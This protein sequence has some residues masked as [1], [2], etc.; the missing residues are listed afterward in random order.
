MFL[1]IILRHQRSQ[2]SM[3]LVHL[4]RI[5]KYNTFRAKPYVNFLKIH[6]NQQVSLYF[7]TLMKISR[8]LIKKRNFLETWFWRQVLQ[9]LAVIIKV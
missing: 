4:I 3:K 5:A 6:M 2:T 1:N 7:L 9:D 8:C